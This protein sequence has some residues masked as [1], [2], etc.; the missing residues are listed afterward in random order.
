MKKESG[1]F[2]MLLAAADSMLDVIIYRSR[3]IS[4]LYDQL[5]VLNVLAS[6]GYPSPERLCPRASITI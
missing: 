3:H 1:D 5:Q 6:R 2:E 4:R